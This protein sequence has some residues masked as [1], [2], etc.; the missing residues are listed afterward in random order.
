MLPVGDPPVRSVLLIHLVKIARRQPGSLYRAIDGAKSV[1]TILMDVLLGALFYLDEGYGTRT[2][3]LRQYT[4]P[5]F[6]SPQ[7]KHQG[8]V[9]NR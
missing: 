8:I 4:I 5:L 2:N 1:G 7:L 6:E 9:R 3:V